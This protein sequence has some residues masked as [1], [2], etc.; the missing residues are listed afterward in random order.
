MACWI[1]KGVTG[2]PLVM[3]GQGITPEGLREVLSGWQNKWGDRKR[4]S[5]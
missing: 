5:V 1:P 4:P 2:V 3:D